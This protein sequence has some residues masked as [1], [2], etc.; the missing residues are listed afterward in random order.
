MLG[1]CGIKNCED[2][3][4]G[5]ALTVCAER[6]EIA[7]GPMGG[8]RPPLELAMDVQTVM[9]SSSG[10]PPSMV[11]AKKASPVSPSSHSWPSVSSEISKSSICVQNPTLALDESEERLNSGQMEIFT[12]S[13]QPNTDGIYF[14]HLCEYTGK[15]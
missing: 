11:D 15:R 5:G 8:H 13:I 6:T 2:V 9:E 1:S 7:K 10:T 12:D 14:C 3:L 4:D